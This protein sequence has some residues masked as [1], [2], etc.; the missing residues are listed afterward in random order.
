MTDSLFLL[1]VR[2]SAVV[3]RVCCKLDPA[4]EFTCVRICCEQRRRPQLETLKYVKVYRVP[5]LYSVG[6]RVGPQPDIGSLTVERALCF[7]LVT[8][9]QAYLCST[10]LVLTLVLTIG[11]YIMTVGGK[12]TRSGPLDLSIGE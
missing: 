2:H 10:G 4:Y 6:L 12:E 7:G 8:R 5:T 11:R 3:H 9:V 1:I